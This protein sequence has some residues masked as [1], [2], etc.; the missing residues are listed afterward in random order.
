MY[1]YPGA[2]MASVFVPGKNTTTRPVGLLPSKLTL[3]ATW[4]HALDGIHPFLTA[5]VRGSGDQLHHGRLDPFAPGIGSD[6][7]GLPGHASPAGALRCVAQAPPPV[8]SRACF[9]AGRRV[10]ATPKKAPWRAPFFQPT[11]T[12]RLAALSA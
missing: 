3:E 11:S 9:S 12:R 10:C 4:V 5:V 2:H 7:S 6:R 1:T 8:H